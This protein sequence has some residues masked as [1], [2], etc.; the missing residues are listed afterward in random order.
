MPNL[1]LM[2]CGTINS[3]VLTDHFIRVNSSKIH[4]IRNIMKKP[5]QVKFR[6]FIEELEI[7]DIFKCIGLIYTIILEKY[8]EPESPKFLKSWCGKMINKA[9]RRI[10]KVKK[11]KENVKNVLANR[12]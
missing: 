10:I 4:V 1:V 8:P 6:E 11:R 12:P 5:R 3:I 2:L 7:N 9:N